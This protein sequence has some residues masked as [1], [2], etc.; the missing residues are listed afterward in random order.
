[1]TNDET[2]HHSKVAADAVA[3]ALR[4]ARSEVLKSSDARLL[5]MI[6]A[7]ATTSMQL[8]SVYLLQKYMFDPAEKIATPYLIDLINDP[9]ERVPV[10]TKEHLA[11]S[12]S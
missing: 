6:L 8:F 1:M 12:V 5:L 11:G 10:L 3:T 2:A 7:S 9:K 4:L